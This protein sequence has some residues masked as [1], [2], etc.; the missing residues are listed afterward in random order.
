MSPPKAIDT[1][2]VSVP[3]LLT[4]QCVSNEKGSYL[5]I[6]VHGKGNRIDRLPLPVD[7]GQAVAT[8]VRI[9]PLR[10]RLAVPERDAASLRVGQPVRLREEGTGTAA[11][12]PV[13]RI[14][15]AVDESTRTLM[16]EAEI[17]NQAG[18]LRPGAFATADIVVDPKQSAVLLPASAI[19]TF[20]GVTK[21]GRRAGERVEVLAGI[22]GGESVVAEPGNLTAGQ[23]VVVE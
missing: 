3:G 18:T 17:P 12:G 14:S 19:V 23:P 15:P 22:A 6:T 7:V 21:V 5:E 4:A 16:V 10:L 9:H 13:V 2:F 1:P 20:A 11:E 8:I